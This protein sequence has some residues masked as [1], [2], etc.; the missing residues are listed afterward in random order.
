MKEYIGDG[1]YAELSPYGY[2]VLTTENGFEATNTIVMEK[3]VLRNFD[4]FRKRMTN[5]QG[6]PLSLRKH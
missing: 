3:F 6:R 1:V 2:I 4:D 5:D